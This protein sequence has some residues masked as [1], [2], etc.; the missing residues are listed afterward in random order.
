MISVT[1]ISVN[2]EY[3]MIVHLSGNWKTAKEWKGKYKAVNV[4]G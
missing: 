4:Y 1:H 2:D 3:L